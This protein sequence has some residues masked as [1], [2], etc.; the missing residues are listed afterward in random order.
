MWC[1][2]SGDVIYRF[3][4]IIITENIAK[5]LYIAQITFYS[6]V[7]SYKMIC[8]GR[9]MSEND[10][11]I[12]N[13]KEATYNM[14][15]CYLLYENGRCKIEIQFWS[16]I[17]LSKPPLHRA[18]YKISL[19]VNKNDHTVKRFSCIDIIEDQVGDHFSE[20]FFPNCWVVMKIT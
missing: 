20:Q 5:A 13:T 17:R 19:W 10:A 12:Q 11:K 1:I 2:K 4:L 15:Q 6:P 7:P 18:G 8:G 3:Q 14:A 16:H 9:F